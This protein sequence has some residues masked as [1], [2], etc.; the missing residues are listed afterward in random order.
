MT[1]PDGRCPDDPGHAP[2]ARGQVLIPSI[3]AAVNVELAETVDDQAR[4]LMYRTHLPA[5]AG[6]LFAMGTRTV[7]TF[8]MENTCIPLDLLFIDDDGLIVGIVE[9]AKTMDPSDLS[10]P[11]P[12]RYVL[13]VNAGWSR[14]M[15]VSPGMKIVI[16][17]SQHE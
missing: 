11:C 1:G 14:R 3:D 12:S 6:M 2:L 4:G 7:H 9:N 8:F 17:R 16:Q 13:E 10:V 15:G 5:D